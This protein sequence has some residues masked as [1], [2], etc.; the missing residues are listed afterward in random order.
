[1]LMSGLSK[2]T[3]MQRLLM[4]RMKSGPSKRRK[5]E[6][7]EYVELDEL[8]SQQT[9]TLSAAIVEA[10]KTQNLVHE[11]IIIGEEI[12]AQGRYWHGL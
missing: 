11:D 3:L 8:Y 6:N 5:I 10:Y 7:P 1:M 2:L 12:I 9:D 4:A